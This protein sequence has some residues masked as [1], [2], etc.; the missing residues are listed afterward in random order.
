MFG[1]NWCYCADFRQCA[2]NLPG[3]RTNLRLLC[4]MADLGPE[5]VGYE[6]A[7]V[8]REVASVTKAQ[9]GHILLS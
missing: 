1:V 2:G 8:I 7:G 5:A 3:P 6:G 9:M 4:L